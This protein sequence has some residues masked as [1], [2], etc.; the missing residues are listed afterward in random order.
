MHLN[1]S[2]SFIDDWYLPRVLAVLPWRL[3]EQ[4]AD[5]RRLGKSFQ[6]SDLLFLLMVQLKPATLDEQDS[7]QRQLC[8]P[9]ACTD[10]QAAL[11]EYRRWR[12]AT[13]R[14]S[15]IGMSLPPVEQLYRD[16]DPYSVVYS[17][18]TTSH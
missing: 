12:A 8:A 10:P 4:V 1:S 16:F 6:V 17:R 13:Q 9:R 3:K 14:A 15:E 5:E 11:R 2:Q 18:E 7:I